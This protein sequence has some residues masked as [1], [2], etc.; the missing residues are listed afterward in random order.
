MP[1]YRTPLI[2]PSR[3][4]EL[5]E[6]GMDNT[7]IAREFQATV[8]GVE[9]AIYRNGL[10]RYTYLSD[11]ELD[12]LIHEQSSNFGEDDGYVAITAYFRSVTTT[13]L[14]YVCIVSMPVLLP[15]SRL[16]PHLTSTRPVPRPTQVNWR[17]RR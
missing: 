1:R 4:A 9:E 13:L 5:L 10:R 7:F 6:A 17:P 16:A 8:R 3:L 2:D 11:E 14:S 15:P 12:A